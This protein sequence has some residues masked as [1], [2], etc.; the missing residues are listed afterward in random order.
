VFYNIGI[1]HLE[2]TGMESLPTTTLKETGVDALKILP[3]KQLI[4][5]LFSSF[6]LGR[7]TF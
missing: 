2:K 6:R 4:L 1:R 7:L 3:S 5:I